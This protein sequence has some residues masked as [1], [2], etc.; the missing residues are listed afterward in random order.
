MRS[1][2]AGLAPLLSPIDRSGIGGALGTPATSTR[3]TARAGR[4]GH[5]VQAVSG[6]QGLDLVRAWCCFA[7]GGE[8]D[9][10]GEGLGEAPWVRYPGA[11]EHQLM[12]DR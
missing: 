3:T 1:G 10:P 8:G 12:G 9:N 11:S 6:L 5:V 2:G 4:G 7:V